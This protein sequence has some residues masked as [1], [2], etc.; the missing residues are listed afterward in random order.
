[1]HLN[2]AT[3]VVLRFLNSRYRI[4][5]PYQFFVWEDLTF[6]VSG[7]SIY[8]IHFLRLHNFHVPSSCSLNHVFPFWSR[9]LSI[10]EIFG[11]FGDSRSCHNFFITLVWRMMWIVL[12]GPLLR[13][14]RVKLHVRQAWVTKRNLLGFKSD[15]SIYFALAQWF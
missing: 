15:Q 8:I 7:F 11:T 3:A 2:A 6:N 13:F 10:I 12:I 9:P 1:M 4:P 5:L 14:T